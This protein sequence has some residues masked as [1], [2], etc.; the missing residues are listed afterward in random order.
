ML[1]I[2]RSSLETPT[3]YG[4]SGLNI[5]PPRSNRDIKCDL[6]VNISISISIRTF[7][8]HNTSRIKRSSKKIL[9]STKKLLHLKKDY[10]YYRQNKQATN[11]F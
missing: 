8:G 1:I 7:R 6:K 9:R 3:I 5:S 4:V 11:K 2:S 10:L